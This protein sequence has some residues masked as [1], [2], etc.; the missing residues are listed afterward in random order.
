MR[1]W[2][3]RKRFVFAG[4]FPLALLTAAV[5][6][7][8]QSDGSSVVVYNETGHTLPPL[9]VGACGQTRS[10]T[11]V[12]D[13]GSVCFHLKGSGPSTPVHLELATD[14]PWTWDGQSVTPAGGVTV[15]VRLWPNR[16]VEA[17]KEVSWWR[18]W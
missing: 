6:A 7:Y 13:Q 15:I 10:F 8:V 3:L 18:Q 2:W 12:E 16:Q 17:N 14:P 4:L 1:P 5:V 11:G 9:L